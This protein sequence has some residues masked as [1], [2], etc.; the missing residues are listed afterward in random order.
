VGLA[1]GDDVGLVVWG[2]MLDVK[3]ALML[4]LMMAF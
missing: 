4:D 2:L 3:S 1:I